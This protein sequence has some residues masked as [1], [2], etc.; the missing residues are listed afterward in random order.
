MAGHRFSAG[1]MLAISAAAAFVVGASA[2]EGMR[3]VRG[4]VT[5]DNPIWGQDPQ[6]TP[7]PQQEETTGRAGRG[8]NQ[9]PPRVRTGRSSRAPRRPTTASSRCIAIG[10]TLYYE[11]PKAELDK[12]FLWVTQIKRTTIGAGYGGQ[13]VGSRVV[14]WV[15]RAIACCSRTSTTASSPI[16][17][18]PIAE[19]VADANNPAIIR[20]FNVAAYAPNGDPVIDVTPLFMTDVAGVLG[21]RRASAAAG[22]DATRSFLEKAVSFPENINVEV[23]ADVHR[24]RRTR[25]PARRRTRRRGARRHARRRR[26]TV[27]MLPQHGEAAREADDAAPVR[28]ARRLL[29][30]GHSPTTAPSEHQSVAEALHHA[31]PP[32]EEGSERGGVRAGEADRLLRRSGDADEVGAVHQEGHRGLAAGVRSG[33]LQERDHREGSAEPNDPDWSPEDVR[34]S[35][36]PLAAV[37]DGERV[38][39]ARARSAQRRDPRS[40]HPVSTT[41][42]RTSRRTGTSCRSGRSIRARRSCRCPT[43]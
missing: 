38:G 14:R 32:R 5:P 2:Q 28:R 12:D 27:L 9:A 40:G 22:M 33:G 11:I 8:G 16:P 13:A 20:A 30:A 10:D 25:R 15:R 31:L 7:P 21:A 34:Y 18:Q 24:R 36:D 6:T 43:I 37:D 41:T 23:D 35:V 39:P 42:S 19:A 4:V 1:W 17:T 29:H 3:A 26:R